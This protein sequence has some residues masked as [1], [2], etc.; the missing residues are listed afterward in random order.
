MLRSPADREAG[1]R[2]FVA[3][4]EWGRL[5]NRSFSRPRIG[6]LTLLTDAVGELNGFRVQRES[7]E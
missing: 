1:G 6:R 3:I 5:G 4:G 7:E 2:G